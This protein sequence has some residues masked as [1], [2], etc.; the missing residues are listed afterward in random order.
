M[1]DTILYFLILLVIC[2]CGKGAIDA[3]SQTVLPVSFRWFT[4]GYDHILDAIYMF[5]GLYILIMMKNPSPLY[6]IIAILFIQKSILHFLV[7][8]RLYESWNLSP[9]TEQILLKYKG[10]Q[11]IIT[12]YGLLFGSLYLLFQIFLQ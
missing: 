7:F 9:Q 10:I 12:D 8:Y 5:V 6:I 1:D 2:S 4:N 3:L 11:S